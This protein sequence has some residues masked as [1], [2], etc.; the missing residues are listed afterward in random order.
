MA[1][2]HIYLLTHSTAQSP[3]SA[4]DWLAASQE[5]SR[6]SRNP[7]VHYRTHKSPPPVSILGQPNPVHI[8]TYHL[9]QIHPNIIHPST[10]RSIQWSLSLRFLHQ[11]PIRPNLLTHTRCVTYWRNATFV[12]RLGEAAAPGGGECGPCPEFASN[13]LAFALQLRII[14][15]YLSQGNSRALGWSGPNAIRLVN[16]AIAGDGIDWPAVP[17]RPWFS[18]QATGSTLG[19]IP[20]IQHPS[21]ESCREPGKIAPFCFL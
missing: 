1:V 10:P 15:E 4:A 3:S 17:Y 7:K 16:L 2:I 20:Y 8:P 6:I 13:T 21:T 9:L 19:S 14:T 18:R 11:D 12:R 5:I